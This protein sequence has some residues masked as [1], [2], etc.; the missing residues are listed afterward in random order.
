MEIQYY[1]NFVQKILNRKSSQWVLSMDQDAEREHLRMG[2]QGVISL[3]P[4]KWIRLLTDQ[5]L[6]S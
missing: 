5:V 1:K 2:G 6:G 4:Y 3:S